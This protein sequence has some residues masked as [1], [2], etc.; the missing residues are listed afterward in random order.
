M[1]HTDNILNLISQ[2]LCQ[3]HYVKV[4][5]IFIRNDEYGKV[6]HPPHG[7]IDLWQR[8]YE[9][10]PSYTWAVSRTLGKTTAKS[11]CQ[12]QHVVALCRLGHLGTKRRLIVTFWECKQQSIVDPWAPHRLWLVVQI[13][14]EIFVVMRMLQL[15][16]ALKEERERE[17]SPA[18]S[19]DCLLV[20]EEQSDPCPCPSRIQH[21]LHL[22]SF[23][24]L[25]HTGSICQ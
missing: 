3:K 15:K 6:A 25:P 13:S 10:C 4:S 20:G 14:R 23:F 22:V 11:I 19:A 7:H 5:T 17:R 9:H 12:N 21:P 16:E 18:L 8:D 24:T 1:S 2:L